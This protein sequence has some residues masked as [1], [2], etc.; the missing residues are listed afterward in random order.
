MAG[1]FISYRQNDGGG[2]AGRL[3]GH[4]SLRFGPNLVRRHA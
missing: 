2:C 1:V 4:L 3:N